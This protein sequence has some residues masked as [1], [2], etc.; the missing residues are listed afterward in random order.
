MKNRHLIS[1]ALALV[2]MTACSEAT[3]VEPADLEGTWTAQSMVFTSVETPSLSV[4]VIPLGAA[5]SLTLEADATFSITMSFPG[6]T[7]ETDTGTYSVS[8]ST[9]TIT[10]EGQDPE[11]FGFARTGDNM[12]ITMDDSFDFT[13]GS[14]EPATLVIGLT[15]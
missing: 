7:A 3:G 9:M 12:T 15:R 14:D 8:G 10:E 1:S 4:D 13:E 5:L 2:L 6:E 11:S